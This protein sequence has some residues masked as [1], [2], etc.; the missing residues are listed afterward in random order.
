M[1]ARFGEQL[2]A[3]GIRYYLAAY[4]LSASLCCV[5]AA[6]GQARFTDLH[7]YRL[8]GQAVWHGLH[9]YRLRYAGLPFS[10]TPFAAACFVALVMLP[11]P[12][13]AA[14]L[15]AASVIALPLMLC[16]VLR[17][18]SVNWALDRPAA[19]RL[20]LAASTVGIWLEPARTTLGYGQIDLLL[21]AAIL[22]DLTRPDARKGVLIGLCAGIKLT[23]AIFI[24]YLLFTRRLRAAVTASAA[25][26]M[27]I[28]IG[29][30]VLPSSSLFFWDATF[31]EPAR[32]SPVQNPENQSLAGV[33]AR[34]VHIS[35]VLPGWLPVLLVVAASGLA[36][37]AR[38]QRQG[39][40]GLGFSLC[41]IT[42]LLI[43]PISWT[44]HWV[45]AI[46]ALL[47]AARWLYQ[48]RTDLR[49]SWLIT[50]TAGAAAVA[51]AGWLDLAR[52]VHGAD[53]LHLSAVDLAESE[54][55][56]VAGVL[57]L[58]A[59]VATALVRSARS[60]ER[61][62]RVDDLVVVV[63]DG[64]HPPLVERGARV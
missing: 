7:V 2:K 30:A 32:I 28:G 50:A 18:A 22:F 5:F 64:D 60:E 9:L 42:G 19:Q 36:V 38:A 17:L 27:T 31:L 58:A 45:I 37:A 14:L 44:H 24:V 20:A 55:Y 25:F 15:T 29:A 23:P 59:A 52:H 47:V 40:E 56:V 13:A 51:I 26:A 35:Q 11:W 4:L 46:P 6:T 8:G 49:R 3:P 34:N 33:I 53:W 16:C 12:A 61:V 62:N 21:G 48:R 57:A 39:N 41:A 43:S 10:Y 63:D 1:L 54:I